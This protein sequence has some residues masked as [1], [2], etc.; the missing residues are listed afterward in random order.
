MCSS[1]TTVQAAHVS[2]LDSASWIQLPG[3]SFLDS[4]SWI[5][6]PGFSFLDAGTSDGLT[7]PTTR[8]TRRLAGIDLNKARNRHVVDAVIELSTRSYGF[9]VA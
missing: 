4:A 1:S 3:F 9:T 8:G 5:Q 7:E 6:L 2:F